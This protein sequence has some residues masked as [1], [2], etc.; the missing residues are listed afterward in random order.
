MLLNST[1]QNYTTLHLPFVSPIESKPMIIW[2]EVIRIKIWRLKKI[3]FTIEYILKDTWN[4]GARGLSDCVDG[5][6]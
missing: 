3:L 2:L 1:G 6:W 4:F 5:S